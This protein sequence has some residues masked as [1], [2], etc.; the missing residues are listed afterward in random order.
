MH[1][2]SGVSC[3][4]IRDSKVGTSLH[5]EASLGHKS[6]PSCRIFV[7]SCLSGPSP[8]LP[9]MCRLF[10][11]LC[12]VGHE[13]LA[14]DSSR[15]CPLPSSF[16]LLP[17]RPRVNHSHSC[18]KVYRPVNRTLHG[19]N[20]RPHPLPARPH[21]LALL[22]RYSLYVKSCKQSWKHMELPTPSRWNS[23]QS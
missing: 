16:P 22:T 3:R 6:L 19:R 5:W 15:T 11:H 18:L 23:A 10:L 20:T 12:L 17:C 13:A 7:R 21:P 2:T 4:N 9:Q 14:P 1:T 8:D